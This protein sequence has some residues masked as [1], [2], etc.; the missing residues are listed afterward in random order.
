ML[1]VIPVL[2]AA[3]VLLLLSMA[4]TLYNICFRRRISGLV[5]WIIR[6]GQDNATGAGTEVDQALAFWQDARPEAVSIQSFDG[7]TLRGDYYHRPDSVRTIVCVHGYRATGLSNFSVVLPIFADLHCDILL[8]DQRACG[9]SDGDTITFGLKERY[10]VRDWCRWLTEQRGC[11][12]PIF[13]DGVSMGCSAVLMACNLDLPDQVSGIIADCGFTS[14]YDI[15]TVVLRRLL[16][17][18]VFPLMP[19]LEWAAKRQLG[20]SLKAV[21]TLDCVRESQIPILFAH[22]LQDH[23][24]PADMCRQNYEACSST[25]WL[26]L[27]PDAA[28][29][30]A[31]LRSRPQYEQLIYQLLQITET[32]Q[33]QEVPHEV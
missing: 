28:H 31:W 2:L 7:L 8:I 24:V 20:M 6:R 27:S 18:P 32:D 9:K 22:G 30:E 14:P 33:P 26:L 29:G 23:F 15:I 19:L 13:L 16:H 3:L 21:N 12:H 11:R 10:D 4:H 1:W 17:L 5:S 25:K